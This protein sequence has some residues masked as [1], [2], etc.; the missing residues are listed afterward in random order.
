MAE[1]INI[2]QAEETD[3]QKIYELV[4]N[5]IEIS[6]KDIYP[7]EAIRAFKNYH[8]RESILDD[9]SKGYTLVIE[10]GDNLIGT[11]TLLDTNVRRVFI[12]PTLQQRGLGKIIALELEKKART[13]GLSTID[14][15]ASIGSVKFWGNLGFEL[16]REAFLPVDNEQ[17]LYYYEMIKH[18]Q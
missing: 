12:Y 1:D 14:L 8:S 15:S 6:Y 7:V 11:G 9:I 3:L 4:S 2:R 18:L 13:G 10:Q 5:T 16:Q 17:K